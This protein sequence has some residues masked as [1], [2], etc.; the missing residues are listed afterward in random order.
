MQILWNGYWGH[1]SNR[2]SSWYTCLWIALMLFVRGKMY[3]KFSTS[4]C[5]DGPCFIY[6]FHLLFGCSGYWLT[7]TCCSPPTVHAGGRFCWCWFLLSILLWKEMPGGIVTIIYCILKFANN[8][9]LEIIHIESLPQLGK[10][11]NASTLVNR[12]L[13]RWPL[14]LL[15]ILYICLNGS[16]I[17]FLVKFYSK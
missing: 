6:S 14:F 15:V 12:T 16:N 4:N 3:V 1:P 5:L 7:F 11:P 2:C 9:Y 13:E 17:M 8:S 10:V